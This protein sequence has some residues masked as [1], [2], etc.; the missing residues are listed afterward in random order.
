MADDKLGKEIVEELKVFGIK[1]QRYVISLGAALGL[2]TRRNTSNLR[3]RLLKFRKRVVRFRKLR[4]A[5]VGIARLMRTGAVKS[6][7][8]GQAVTGVANTTLLAQRRAVAA[9]LAPAAGTRGQCLDMTLVLADG[10]AK[11]RADPAF[12]AHIDPIGQ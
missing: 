2:G 3:N 6:L 11:G 4:K 1:Y 10:K 8:Y 12:D 9:A 5:K 7:T